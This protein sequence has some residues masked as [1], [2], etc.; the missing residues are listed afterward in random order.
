MKLWVLFLTSALL[1]NAAGWKAGVATTVITPTRPIWMAGYSARSQASQGK[2][3]DIYVKALALEDSSGKRVV[4]V[5]TDLLGVTKVVAAEVAARVNKQYGLSRERLMF[6]S[7]HTHC[8]PV[9]GRMLAVAYNLDA[10]QWREIDEYTKDL[11]E[12]MVMT[13]GHALRSLHPARLSFGH[14]TAGFAKNRRVQYSPNGPVD[15]DVPILRVT[16]PAGRLRA[17]VFGYACHNTTLPAEM[18]RISGDYAGFAQA[19][20]E[21]QH[22]RAVAMF[23]MGCGADANPAPRGTEESARAHGA[24]L[25]KAVG[26]VLSDPLQAVSAS[27][28]AAFEKVSLAFDTPPSREELE[29]RTRDK[30][31]YV[32]KHARE[33]LAIIERD[34]RL[35]TDYP[36]PIQVWRFG[37]DLTWIALAGEVVVDYDLR[38]KKMFGPERLWVSGYSNDVFAYIPSERVLKEGGYEGGGAMIYYVQPGRWAPSVESTIISATERMVRSLSPSG[39]VR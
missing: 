31:P 2:L 32:A 34:G 18:C 26:R 28:G 23:V 37:N 39:A 6:N 36:Y 33:M 14:S 21:K 12:K 20:L 19:E 3:Q 24:A 11:Q 17:V 25:S 27:V 13:I 1:L 7:S 16:D 5:T 9:I 35:P 10:S 15:H 22:P 38:L 8:A 4:L 29:S 30:N